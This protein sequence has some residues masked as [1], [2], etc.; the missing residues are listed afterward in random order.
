MT[1]AAEL[2]AAWAELVNNATQGPLEARHHYF[3][4]G[5][6]MQSSVV[7][8]ENGD[9]DEEDGSCVVVNSTPGDADL[10]AASRTAVPVMSAA[11][12]A[13]LNEAYCTDG[14][15][16]GHCAGC[17]VFRAINAALGVTA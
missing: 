10:F 8:V 3:Q 12:T 9:F 15:C 1:T 14:D 4:D 6:W 7:T 17:R 2:I 5:R 16:D 11:L 13:A